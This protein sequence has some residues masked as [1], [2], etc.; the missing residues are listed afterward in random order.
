MLHVTLKPFKNGFPY[1]SLPGLGE[2]FLKFIFGVYFF[3]R[4]QQETEHALTK[5]IQGESRLKVLSSYMS[6]SSLTHNICADE[7]YS[8]EVAAGVFRGVID[9]A[10]VCGGVDSAIVVARNLG[11]VMDP[12]ARTLAKIHKIYQRYC[13]LSVSAKPP[14]SIDSQT[15]DRIQRVQI[16]L[17]Y[18]FSDV[19][20]LLQAITHK[21]VG[22]QSYERLE[23]LGDAV[24][25]FAVANY[26]H[27]KFPFS[28]LGKFR[29]FKQPVLKN[30]AL[31]SFSLLLD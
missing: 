29:A 21:S 7:E 31:D 19:R 24:L 1:S 27:K 2:A 20:L 5:R 14:A 15:L 9:A 26:H 11:L 16:A 8:H 6:S 4:Y 30:D 3:V 17:G 23:L 28:S 22:T 18:S 10:V 25:E 13:P 12:T